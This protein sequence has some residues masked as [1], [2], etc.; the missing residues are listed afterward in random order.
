VDIPGTG[1][2]GVLCPSSSLPW[3]SWLP[4]SSSLPLPLPLMLLLLRLALAVAEGV[5]RPFM[6]LM[7]AWP[8]VGTTQEGKQDV[9]QGMG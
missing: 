9:T 8:L 5:R 4:P 3:W 6:L 7:G 1:L 2:A